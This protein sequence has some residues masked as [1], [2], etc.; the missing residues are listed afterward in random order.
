MSERAKR[1]KHVISKSNKYIQH[2]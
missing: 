1:E 2:R